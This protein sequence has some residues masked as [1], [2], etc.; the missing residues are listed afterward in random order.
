M[1][2]RVQYDWKG[3]SDSNKKTGTVRRLFVVSMFFILFLG[4]V[5]HFW[6]DGSEFL[7]NL[8]LPGDAVLTWNALEQ[9][10]QNLYGGMPLSVAA[11]E[12]YHGVLQSV[13]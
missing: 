10:M 8:L 7:V 3:K 12:F 11:Q 4:L 2:Y 9:L 1:S 13:Y 5:F 6:E